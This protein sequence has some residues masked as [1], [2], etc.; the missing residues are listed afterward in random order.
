MTR[1]ENGINIDFGS[2]TKVLFDYLVRLPR[3]QLATDTAIRDLNQKKDKT[4]EVKVKKVE[5]LFSSVSLDNIKPMIA[6]DLANM[7]LTEY[8]YKEVNP[9]VNRV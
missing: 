2:L 3:V 9:R 7:S 4:W 8:L 6:T 5:D 1:V